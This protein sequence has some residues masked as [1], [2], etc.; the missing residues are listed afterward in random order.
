M[1]FLRKPPLYIERSWKIMEDHGRSRIHEEMENQAL[2]DGHLA[3][4][5]QTCEKSKTIEV[6]FHPNWV[7]LKIGD[8]KIPWSIIISPFK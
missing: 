1:V 4:G 5:V 3:R 6:L 7:C 2:P 8:L